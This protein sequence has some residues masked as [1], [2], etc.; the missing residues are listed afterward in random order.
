MCTTGPQ[1]ITPPALG[2]SAYRRAKQS[3]S[4]RVEEAE[5]ARQEYEEWRAQQRRMVEEVAQKRLESKGSVFVLPHVLL[6]VWARLC[7]EGNGSGS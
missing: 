7:D 3:D 4:D 6:L 5:R 1:G 2:A